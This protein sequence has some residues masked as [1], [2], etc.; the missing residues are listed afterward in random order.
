MKHTLYGADGLDSVLRSALGWFT[1]QTGIADGTS[2]LIPAYDLNFRRPLAF[3]S[4]A[5]GAGP[6]VDPRKRLAGVAK[7]AVTHEQVKTAGDSAAGQ[8]SGVLSSI[9][10]AGA[11]LPDDTS[12]NMSAE[13][14]G[15]GPFSNS[16]VTPR[17][18]PPQPRGTG[19]G[20][21]PG[22]R[23]AKPAESFNLEWATSLNPCREP[24]GPSRSHSMTLA[25]MEHREAQPL[26]RRVSWVY[27]RGADFLLREVVRASC[28]APTFLP[29]A[30]INVL[31]PD[32]G[33]GKE[34]LCID[35]GVAANNP[36][37]IALTFCKTIGH[38][39]SN[40]AILSLGTGEPMAPW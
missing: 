27:S 13:L 35:G 16:H 36:S 12:D 4:V 34:L 22:R 17:A 10:T 5:P 9:I 30:T 18:H 8:P 23:S 37:M 6:L 21:E 3:Y 33:P 38:D 20:V 14:D 28:S 2:L 40:T 26:Q 31:H 24:P 1:L 29:A 32:G 11:G 15:K 7:L 19:A 25:N 39:P